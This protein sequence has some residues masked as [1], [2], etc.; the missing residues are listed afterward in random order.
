MRQL[1]EFIQLM[2]IEQPMKYALFDKCTEVC[3]TSMNSDNRF[4]WKDYI[5]PRVEYSIQVK[6]DRIVNW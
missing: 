4:I 2:P 6:G 3:L 1:G 5:S